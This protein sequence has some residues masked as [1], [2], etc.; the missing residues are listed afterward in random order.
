M[1][2]ASFKDYVLEQLR[3]VRGVSARAMFGGWGLYKGTVMFGLIADG[4]LFFKA[5][6]RS[7]A[8]FDERK[9][10]PFTYTTKGGK[11]A[12]MSYFQVPED[13]IEDTDDLEAWTA[14]AVDAALA[15]KK[16]KKK[17]A[18]PKPKSRTSRGPRG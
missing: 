11:Q 13:V 18:K 12:S 5:D 7:R 1:A 3:D 14:R 2:D 15:K 4:E 9:A 10:R 16:A 8:F 17:P 6:D